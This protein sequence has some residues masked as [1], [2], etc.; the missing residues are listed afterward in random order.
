MTDNFH[1]IKWFYISKPLFYWGNKTR[2]NWAHP[3]S[4]VSNRK[5]EKFSIKVSA[6]KKGADAVA[7]KIRCVLFHLNMMKAI[8]TLEY[9][10]P[11]VERSTCC[12][13]ALQIDKSSS[14]C[15][16][17]AKCFTSAFLSHLKMFIHCCKFWITSAPFWLNENM[18]C[19]KKC[20]KFLR[21]PLYHCGNVDSRCISI[22]ISY[23]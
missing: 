2:N 16:P 15:G 19:L 1:L 22:C 6:C 10:I 13:L 23:A 7:E 17:S 3:Y 21:E 12:S 5:R 11:A 14:L 18:F 8:K 20:E 9:S 4:D